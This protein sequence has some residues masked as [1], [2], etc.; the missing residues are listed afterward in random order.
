MV[1]TVAVREGVEATVMVRV[2]VRVGVSVRVAVKLG[3][4]VRVAI[5]RVG[6]GDKRFATVRVTEGA[7]FDSG[8]LD[9]GLVIVGISVGA[10]VG[11]GAWVGVASKVD[12]GSGTVMMAREVGALIVWLVALVGVVKGTT[13]E[14][15]N[16]ESKKG[17]A[18]KLAKPRQYSNNTPIVR[19]ARQP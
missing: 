14:E 12:C 4:K 3:V 7:R 15:F 2:A 10:R 5:P 6:V 18:R 8:V 16:P 11:R 9:A 1:I 17:L 19:L 13:W